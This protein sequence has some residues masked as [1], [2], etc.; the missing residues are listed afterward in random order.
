MSRL[1]VSDCDP[2]LFEN[3]L[4]LREHRLDVEEQ[5]Q[6]EI[7]NVDSLKKEC[8]TLG[9]K[10]RDNV[11]PFPPFFLFLVFQKNTLKRQ[12]VGLCRRRLCKIIARQQRVIWSSLIKKSSKG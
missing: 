3:T 6:E 4:R 11:F 7:K 1:C 9:K 8:D 10:V 12:Y 5:L 2:E